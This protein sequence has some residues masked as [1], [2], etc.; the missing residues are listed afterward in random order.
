MLG[1]LLTGLY[2]HLLKLYPDRFLDEF[3]EEMGD[4]FAQALSGLDDSVTPPATRRLKMVRLFFRE[5]WYFPLAYL[6]ARRYP[7]SSWA[8]CSPAPYSRSPG[9]SRA[10]GTTGRAFLSPST[11]LPCLCLRSSSSMRIGGPSSST[12]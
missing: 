1:R 2:F 10:P 6:D 3:G 9:C 12:A 4:V 5:V 11:L 8:Y 7:A